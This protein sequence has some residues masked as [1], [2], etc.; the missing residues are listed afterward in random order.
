MEIKVFSQAY[1]NNTNIINLT[2]TNSG[3]FCRKVL[4]KY[5]NEILDNVDGCIFKISYLEPITNWKFTDFVSCVEFTASDY[6]AYISDNIYRNMC[7][8]ELDY[9]E[10]VTIELY[11]PPQANSITFRLSDELLDIIPDLKSTLEELLINNYKFIKLG[12]Y[13]E[14]LNYKIMV[15]DLQ[16]DTVCMINNTDVEVDFEIITKINKINNTSFIAD[17]IPENEIPINNQEISNINNDNLNNTLD[18]ENETPILSIEELRLKR[19][20]AL[21]K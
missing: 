17:L 16:P 10:K 21:S 9:L 2:N 14:L 5:E 3:I 20:E 18:N 6:T 15:S 19:L 1:N 13:I 7:S 8:M 12:Q 4:E 11:N